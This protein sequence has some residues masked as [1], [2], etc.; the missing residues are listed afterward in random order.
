MVLKIRCVKKRWID[1]IGN[2]LCQ[3]PQNDL[4]SVVLKILDVKNYCFEFVM[5]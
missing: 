1:F 3:V 4:I 2:L 5:Y